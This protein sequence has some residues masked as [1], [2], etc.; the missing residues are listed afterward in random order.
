MMAPAVEVERLKDALNQDARM[1]A[2]M[3]ENR[4]IIRDKIRR[5]RVKVVIDLV[6]PGTNLRKGWRIGR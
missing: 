6:L 3:D 1:K 4:N 5:E 2:G